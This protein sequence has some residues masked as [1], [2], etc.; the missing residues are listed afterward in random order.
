LEVSEKERV[1]RLMQE[2]A[3]QQRANLR[4]K[5]EKERR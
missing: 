2:H 3:E 1:D 5:H 4:R